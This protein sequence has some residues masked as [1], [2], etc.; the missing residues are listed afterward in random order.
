MGR[1][2][3]EEL[4]ERIADEI[5]ARMTFHEVI[6]ETARCVELTQKIKQSLLT[7][8]KLVKEEKWIEVNKPF[9]EL[10]KNIGIIRTVCDVADADVV[11]Q[12]DLFLQLLEALEGKNQEKIVALT[13]PETIVIKW[14]LWVVI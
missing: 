1:M 4:V 9:L 2:S 10:S 12:R 14:K 5:R 6:I 7:I 3:E 13:N 11:V 8:R